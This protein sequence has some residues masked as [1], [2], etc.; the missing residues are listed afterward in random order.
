MTLS[1]ELGS[2]TSPLR[3]LLMEHLPGLDK[4]LRAELNRTLADVTT[5]T[6][7]A[8]TGA[9][10]S[11]LG[12]AI[13]HRIVLTRATRDDLIFNEGLDHTIVTFNYKYG[14]LC[15]VMRNDRLFDELRLRL[16]EGATGTLF[17]PSQPILGEDPDRA[18]R[19][20]IVLGLID[21][22][23]RSQEPPEALMEMATTKSTLD[24]ALAL[25]DQTWVDDVNAVTELALPLLPNST[26]DPLIISPEMSGG[27]LVGRAEADLL[28]HG[29]LIDIKTSQKW[30]LPL[31]TLL[32]SFCY[33][34]LD[35]DDEHE[36]IQT[37]VLLARHGHLVV[38]NV[39]DAL[40]R[41]GG[42]TLAQ[43]RRRVI[44]PLQERV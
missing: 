34:L 16:H 37:A 28:L 9:P 3:Q 1:R 24:D 17:P 15:P 44:Q 7:P 31:P 19:L 13:E 22:S 33:A 27:H 26:E 23:W 14:E 39:K 43:T 25:I 11:T 4:V 20:A 30:R 10:P 21:Q 6:I 38:W 8:P 12:H 35:I 41:A 36:I 18:A 42:L 29:T 2:S 40:E 32:R 5:P